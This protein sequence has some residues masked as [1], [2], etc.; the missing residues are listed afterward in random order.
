MVGK[1]PDGQL[2]AE[3]VDLMGM[4]LSE[5]GRAKGLSYNIASPIGNGTPVVRC[6]RRS[7]HS[8]GPF[9]CRQSRANQTDHSEAL[10]WKIAVWIVVTSR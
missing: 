4:P 8:H 3:P 10:A 5:D 2:L 6:T 7:T 1:G 9:G